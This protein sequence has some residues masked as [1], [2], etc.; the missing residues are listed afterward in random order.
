MASLIALEVISTWVTR[1]ISSGRKSRVRFVPMASLEVCESSLNESMGFL[2]TDHVSAGTKKEVVELHRNA[3][4]MFAFGA[5]HKRHLVF[6]GGG[7]EGGGACR[8]HVTATWARSSASSLSS[9][10]AGLL[11]PSKLCTCDMKPDCWLASASTSSRSSCT[12]ASSR[13]Y[14]SPRCRNTMSCSRRPS[15]RPRCAPW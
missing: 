5:S 14:P 11:L 7:G 8:R 9:A 10:S 1:P 13:S 2:K 12:S 3:K 15:G 4:V 6:V